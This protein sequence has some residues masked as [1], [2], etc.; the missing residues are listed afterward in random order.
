[1]AYPLP[2]LPPALGAPVAVMAGAARGHTGTVVSRPIGRAGR[3]VRV[4]L[5][6]LDSSARVDWR[7]LAPVGTLPADA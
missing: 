7:H 1:V 6:A 2:L 3:R 5:D 4:Q